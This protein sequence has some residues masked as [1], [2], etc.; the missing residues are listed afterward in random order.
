MIVVG[1]SGWQFD[2]WD[3][4]FYASD[5]PKED[6][7]SVY[8]TSFGSVEVNNT[9]YQRPDAEKLRRWR[10]QTP[11]SFTFSIK[12]N[13]YITHLKKFIDPEEPLQTLYRSLEPLGDRLGPILFQC[14]PNWH[15]NVDRLEAF[16]DEL[17]EHHRHA[18]EFRDSTWFHPATLD[19]L[20]RHDA[21]FCIY[22]LGSKQR[23]PIAQ[24]ADFAYVRLHGPETAYE[25]AY[26][27]EAL[28]TWARR[29]RDWSR[30]GRDVFVY[31]NNT[32]G[33]GHAPFDARRFRKVLAEMD[34]ESEEPEAA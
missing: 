6:W 5:T 28:T 8:A 4:R 19:A 29:A 1:T 23:S 20:T 34:A 7:L 17:S 3:G 14:P 22:E 16:L 32:S 30:E 21:A 24:T 33:E 15:Q 9:F 12:A 26:S 10:E 18:F 13:R 27:D 11:D 25:G 2:N 31:F